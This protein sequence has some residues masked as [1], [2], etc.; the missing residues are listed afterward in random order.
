MKPEKR[1]CKG[2]KLDGSPCFAAAQPNSD[3]CFFHDPSKS[4]ERHT[5]QSRGG[6][7]NRMKTLDITSPDVRLQDAGDVAAL[8]T[9]T[10]NQVRT[11]QI[12]P[13]VAYTVGYLTNILI[14]VQ[15][16]EL[17]KRIQRLEALLGSST[18]VRDLTMSGVQ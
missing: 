14:K 15:Q 12:D 10:I 13:R 11:G 16:Q 6:R 7:Q 3:Y 8:M 1:T 4:E 5:A 18:K 17:E 9:Q 2:A